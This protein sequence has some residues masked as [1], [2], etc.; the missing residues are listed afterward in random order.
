MN[1]DAIEIC[2]AGCDQDPTSEDS[3]A[4]RDW[5]SFL[6]QGYARTA[7]GV[8]DQHG[9]GW[10]GKARTLVEVRDD[11]PGHLDTGE[12]FANLKAGRAVVVNGPFVTAT[13]KDDGGAPVGLGGLAK[14]TKGNQLVLHVKVQA[15]SWIP[16]DSISVVENGVAKASASV[17]GGGQVVRFDEDILVDAPAADAWYV[18]IVES[19]S[20]MAPVLG[21][22][23]RAVTNAIYVDRNGNGKFDAPTP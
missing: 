20:P 4:M 11:D 16:V 10:V 13:I 7:V 8:S 17:P 22:L 9:G 3:R 14:T 23:P 18:I 2:N 12:V 1:W 15:P 19:S 21:D 5:F 6:S